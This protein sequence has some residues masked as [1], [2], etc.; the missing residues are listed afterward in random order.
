MFSFTLKGEHMARPK[1]AF[2]GGL[3]ES[4]QSDLDIVDSQGVAV[5]LTAIVAVAKHKA[6]LVADIM[7]VATQTIWRWVKSYKKEGIEGLYPKSK[8]PKSS[9][10]TA[11]QKEEIL[12]WVDNAKTP[13]GKRAHW[14]LEKLRYAITEEFGVTL[15]INTI[16]VWLRKQDRKLKVPRPRHYKADE[17]AQAGFKKN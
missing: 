3:A 7:G 6:E 9:K 5:K 14:T 2:M 15:G 13:K 10:L 4:A 17:Q 11:M 16:W 8:R 12:A 1:P